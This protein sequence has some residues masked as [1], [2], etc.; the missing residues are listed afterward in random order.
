M[1]YRGSIFITRTFVQ[2]TLIDAVE[3]TS[4]CFIGSVVVFALENANPASTY[5][6][7]NHKHELHI[8]YIV[9]ILIW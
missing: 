8:P 6:L 5:P 2:F 7:R 4:L 1:R 3:V 9:S